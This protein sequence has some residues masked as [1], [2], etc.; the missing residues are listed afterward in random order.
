MRVSEHVI[1]IV[2]DS[3]HPLGAL[4]D[5][6]IILLE[7]LWARHPNPD[8]QAAWTRALSEL[9]SKHYRI[10]FV[11]MEERC[12]TIDENPRKVPRLGVFNGR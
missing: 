10:V 6:A 3:G 11:P 5:D 9:S 2:S 12:L 4:A 8:I 7:D 1:E